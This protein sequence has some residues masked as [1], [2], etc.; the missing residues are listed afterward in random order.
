VLQHFNLYYQRKQQ[1]M[2][3]NIDREIQQLIND[4]E[5]LKIEFN[6]K[7]DII[8]GKLT[9]LRSKVKRNTPSTPTI[10]L[11]AGHIV[12]ITNNYKGT[13]G[14]VGTIERVTDKQVTLREYHTNK[15]YTRSKNNVK[16]L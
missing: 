6:T 10:D 11:E 15:I 3:N 16:R 7:S 2:P 4:F 9:K 14:I 13:K 12:E 1:H 8:T 5:Q